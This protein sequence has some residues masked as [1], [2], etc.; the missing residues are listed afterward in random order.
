ML[1]DAVML[2][3]R[4]P[5]LGCM[6]NVEKSERTWPDN[7]HIGRAN[8]HQYFIH[9]ETILFISLG[10]KL[11]DLPLYSQF[12]RFTSGATNQSGHNEQAEMKLSQESR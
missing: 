6:V 2:K 8:I 11:S 9:A 7:I 4:K 5:V 10:T 1:E 12:R 3:E